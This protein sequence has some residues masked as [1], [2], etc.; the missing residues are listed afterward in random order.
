MATNPSN[1]KPQILPPAREKSGD[2]SPSSSREALQALLAFSTLHDQIRRRRTEDAQRYAVGLGPPDNPWETDQFMLDEV[3]QLVAERAQS[4]TGADGIAIALADG[5]QIICRASVGAMAPDRGMQLEPKSGFSGA[6]M[7]ARRI[8]RCDDSENDPRV[9]VHACRGLGTRSMV[10]VP[11]MGQDSVLG[12]LEAFST[13]SFAFSDNHVRSLSLLSE[14]I[15]AALKP[16]DEERIVRA[17]RVAAAEFDAA[18]V[19]QLRRIPVTVQ[20]EILAPAVL[21]PTV[22]DAADTPLEFSKENIAPPLFEGST[23][24]DSRQKWL[25]AG[26]ALIALL[27][28]AGIW[29]KT[30]GHSNAPAPVAAVAPQNVKT[31]SGLAPSATPASS[32]AAPVPAALKPSADASPLTKAA[33]LP[34]GATPQVTG[35]R[36]WSDNGATTVEIALQ[37]EVQYETHRLDNPDRIYF[38]LRDTALAAALNARTIEV[39]DNLLSKIR[40]AQ[41]IDG[42]TRVVLDTKSISDF[43]VR[44]EQNPYRLLIELHGRAAKPAAAQPAPEPAP[45]TLPP[46]KSPSQNVA[47]TVPTPAAAS[48]PAPSVALTIASNA[49]PAAIPQ[50]KAVPAIVAPQPEMRAHAGHLK[51][52]LDAGHGGWDLGTVGRHGLLEKDLVLDVAQRLGKLVETRLGGEVLFTRRDDNY[53]SLEQR[54]ELANQAQADMFVSVHANYSDLASARGV[55]TYYSSFFL[56]PEVREAELRGTTHAAHLPS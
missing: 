38:D 30:R 27:A 51:I 11:L 17:A 4:I 5:E 13:E 21:A 10:A 36:H 26:A 33:P 18:E 29:W 20:P 1:A 12:L 28:F 37:S 50:P 31:E 56:P 41:P 32:S 23:P 54:A 25:L 39:G 15:L 9:D 6:C 8:I 43:S 48:K 34:D 24:N 16:E 22:N 40:V 7:S 44:L 42:V 14:L 49:P 2:G 55:E 35:I 46:A 52:V 47:P 45:K 19:E 53:L 3:L